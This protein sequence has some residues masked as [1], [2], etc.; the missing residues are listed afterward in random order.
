M[1]RAPTLEPFASDACY[2][3]PSHQR[4]CSPAFDTATVFVNLCWRRDTLEMC[5]SGKMS[6]QSR[7]FAQTPRAPDTCALSRM[8]F[9][10]TD[11][12]WF[13]AGFGTEFVSIHARELP[14]PICPSVT[15]TEATT[16]SAPSPSGHGPR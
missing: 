8:L 12:L 2:Q 5:C 9:T 10:E 1:F 14:L 13:Q 16:P 11:T 6:V 3:G 7:Q 15:L 4:M